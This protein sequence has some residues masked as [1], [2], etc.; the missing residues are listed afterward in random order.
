[1]WVLA[2]DSWF[3]QKQQMLLTAEKSLKSPRKSILKNYLM[4]LAY[5]NL[6]KEEIKNKIKDLKI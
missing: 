2:T 3:L 1:M 5:D 6:V 4:S